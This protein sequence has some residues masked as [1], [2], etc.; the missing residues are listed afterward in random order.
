M[1]AMAPLAKPFDNFLPEAYTSEGLRILSG[2]TYWADHGKAKRFLGYN[3][4]PLQEGLASTLR[5]EMS[6]LGM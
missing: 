3:P 1:K 5:H 4:R 6:L 2:V